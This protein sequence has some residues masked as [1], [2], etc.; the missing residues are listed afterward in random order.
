VKSVDAANHSITLSQPSRGRDEAPTEKTYTVSVDAEI[1][2]DDGRGKRFSIKEG[3]LSDV[4]AGAVAVI[5][6][7]VDQ[8]LV[9]GAT[10]EGPIVNGVVKSVDVNKNSL[11]I[12]SGGGGRGGSDAEERTVELAKDSLVLID[13]GKGRRFSLKEGKL[14]DIPVGSVVSAKLS[15][16]QRYAP[17]GN[18]PFVG[19]LRAE[20]PQL[21]AMLKSIDAMKGT[22]TVAVQVSRGENPDE[23]T[24]NIAKDARITM[25]GA[26]VKLADVKIEENTFVQL[27]LS[28]DQKTVQSMTIGTGRR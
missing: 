26:A 13:D 23:R 6:L 19:T 24:L 18:F 11:T 15:A 22:V 2:I 21:G 27:R 10:I 25:E 1:A 5:W 28:L 8:K 17:S 7:S 3:K 9:T 16:D 12:A 20:G 4:A 14:A